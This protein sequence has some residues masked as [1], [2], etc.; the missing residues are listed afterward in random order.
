MSANSS[1]AAGREGRGNYR[2]KD[3]VPRNAVRRG[4]VSK[5]TDD[6]MKTAINDCGKTIDASKYVK[7]METMINY[8]N[9][10]GWD[11][12]SELHSA[13]ID[14]VD[15]LPTVP[16]PTRPTLVTLPDGRMIVNDP[17]EQSIY[18][19]DRK[20]TVKYNTKL[21]TELTQ[22]YGELCEAIP[23]IDLIEEIRPFG[24]AKDYIPAKVYC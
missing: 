21:T 9:R 6:A 7:S 24:L 19:D 16:L 4:Y 8:I 17:I 3:R 11:F 18:L 5:H 20:T 13:L 1:V 12:T 2:N 15:V 14:D 10:S 22:L 23:I